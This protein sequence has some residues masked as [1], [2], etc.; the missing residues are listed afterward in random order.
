MLYQSDTAGNAL[1][2]TLAGGM[3]VSQHDA[4]GTSYFLADAL[5][6]TRGLTNSSGD[7]VES[8]K[9]D[10]F[11]QL[12]EGD[13]SSTDYLFTGQE[14]DS[15]TDLYNLRARYYSPTSGRFLSQDTWAIDYNTPVE[16]N[17]YAYAANNPATYSDPSGHFIDYSSILKRVSVR[18][19]PSCIAIR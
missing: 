11:G 5:G 19:T 10:A 8:Y 13:A 17:R 15:T 3:L 12:T 2:F 9:Y 1:S 14:Y 4:A 18:V 6:S 16:Y 7:V